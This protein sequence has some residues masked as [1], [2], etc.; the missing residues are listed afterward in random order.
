MSKTC[1]VG[2]PLQ[3]KRLP[4]GK[5]QLLTPLE[6]SICGHYIRIEQGFVT[7]FS[8]IPTLLSWIVRWSRV[9]V[10]GVVH[11]ALFNP[12]GC[13]SVFA[14]SDPERERDLV[15]EITI[16]RA[17]KIWSE[18]ARSGSTKGRADRAQAALCHLG[19]YSFGWRTWNKYRGQGARTVSLPQRVLRALVGVVV[20]VA[21]LPGLLA[22]C[23]VFAVF[24]AI[25]AVCR[26]VVSRL[27]KLLASARSAH[28]TGTGTQESG[29]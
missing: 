13:C 17:D 25:H 18:V 23:V 5:R 27:I 11:D 4:D 7:D 19:L 16:N 15:D 9:D 26:V 24:A 10:A 21:F 28:L 14:H 1:V 29:P 20:G 6:V 8:S 12:S 3:T 22:L 2:A